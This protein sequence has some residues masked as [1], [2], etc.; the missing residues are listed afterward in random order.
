MEQNE[1]IVNEGIAE[2]T[3]EVVKP[4]SG[5]AGKVVLGALVGVLVGSFIY[6]KIKR[7]RAKAKAEKEVEVT[8]VK[9]VPEEFI[10]DEDGNPIEK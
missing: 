1:L 3:A 7:H 6:K 8:E 2:A 10:Y 4:R 9:S 5:K